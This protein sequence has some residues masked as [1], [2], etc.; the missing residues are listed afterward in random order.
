MRLLRRARRAVST[1]LEVLKSGKEPLSLSEVS[2]GRGILYIA[3]GKRYV[4]EAIQSRSSVR[5]V[6]QLPAAII[7]DDVNHPGL[8][9]FDFIIQ[10][11]F[12][13]PRVKVE[14]LS[15]SPFERTLYLDSDTFVLEDPT[16]VID[17]LEKFDVVAA[18]DYARFRKKWAQKYRKYRQI[19]EAFSEVNG[20]VLGYRLPQ[21]LPMLER[22]VSEYSANYRI[23]KWD[24][25][26][27]RV[28][29]YEVDARLYIMPPE[30]NLRSA[31][32]RQKNIS[33]PEFAGKP[34]AFRP[35][36]LHWHGASPDRVSESQPW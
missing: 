1:R 23:S 16:P 25:P 29:L 3:F 21:A 22:W 33:A 32:I 6:S 34:L 20:G 12:K 14:Y 35:R 4:D 9:Q 28:A 30:W 18:H 15:L 7:T 36:I 27:L 2:E 5:S 24:Q 31:S 19:P 13:H 10:K 8:G 26:S 17:L 11:P